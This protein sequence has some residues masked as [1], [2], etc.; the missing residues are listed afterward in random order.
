MHSTPHS[1]WLHWQTPFIP[2][3][4]LLIVLA[5]C[6][7]QPGPSDAKGDRKDAHSF[8][9]PD[10]AV[11]KH[12]DL[13]LAVDFKKRR[14]SGRAGLEI[15]NK[16][17]TD[18]L[19]LDSRDL[20]I[21]RVTLDADEQEAKFSLGEPVEYLGQPLIIDITPETKLVNVYYTTSPKAAALQWLTPAQTSGGKYPFLFTQSEAILAR[22]WIPC[23]D[24]PG[25][26]FTYHAKIRTDPGLMAVMSA[27]N[28]TQKSPDGVYEFNMPQRIPSYLL[29]LAVGD[30]EFRALGKRSGVYAEPSVVDKAAWEFA[31][32][33]KMIEA[34][35]RLYGPYRWGRYDIIVLPPSFPFGGMENPRLTFATPTV[36]AGDRS[37]VALI[38]HELAHSWSGNYVTNATWNDFWLNEGVTSYIENRIMEEIYG[39]DYADMLTL[40]SYRDLQEEIANL[41]EKSPDT[42]L[43]LA[44]AGRDPD[45]GMTSIAYDKGQF[46]LRTLERY[47]GR[48]TWD[49]FLRSYFK[50]F[51]FKSVTSADF[52]GYLR[53]KL[54]KGD[55][56]LEKSLQIDAW[57]YGPGIP[58]NIVQ[59]HSDG[60]QKVEAQVK[61]WIA[62][63]PTN[64]LETAG[65]ST[66]EWLHFLHKLPASMSSAQMRQLDTAFKFTQTGNSEIKFAW[67]MHVIPSKYQPAYPA[68]EDF[69]TSQGR[70]KFLKPLYTKLAETPE[71]F[72]MAEKIYGQARPT[73]HAISSNTIDEIL[74]WQQ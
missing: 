52:V 43:H 51:A 7:K 31:D 56:K 27:E 18:K 21:E 45:E 62:G 47:F 16:S 64:Q 74:H 63:K 46:F 49:P 36:L 19:F 23:Q 35:E 17:G 55:R 70:R 68:L 60:F 58:E 1:Q 72:K 8:A 40:L 39:K 25:V 22:T 54:V 13:D 67:L 2:L 33:E 50:A 66:L 73:Y 61:D 71:G 11:V 37:L 26:R 42:H 59:V 28:S 29:A 14:I 30:L 15:E 65:W 69:L 32:T 6:S 48:E 41:G 10:E 9:R 38:A 57:V 5:A 12:L 4:G 44:L 53:K 3:F 34:T 24:S 20:T